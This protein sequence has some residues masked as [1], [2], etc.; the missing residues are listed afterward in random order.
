MAAAG[1]V[2]F[3]KICGFLLRGFT[4]FEPLDLGAW[5]HGVWAQVPPRL[6]SEGFVRKLEIRLSQLQKTGLGVGRQ[7]IDP[8]LKSSGPHEL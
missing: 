7:V 8:E 2:F 1:P 4:G 5:T 3:V 6:L